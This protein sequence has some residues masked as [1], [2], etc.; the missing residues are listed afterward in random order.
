MPQSQAVL[1]AAARLVRKN[2]DMQTL[3]IQHF[4]TTEKFIIGKYDLEIL[5]L[6]RIKLDKVD[7]AQ[8]KTT[9][10]EIPQAGSVTI[11]K[12]GE[13]P[14]QLFLEENNKQVWVCNLNSSLTQETINLQPGKYRIEYRPKNAK[15]VIYSIERRFKIDSGISTQVK[16]Y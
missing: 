16:L 14:G 11:A 7:V 2:G 9:F 1:R 8:S 13:G 3:H 4:N 15:E 5:T 12:P 6:P 10:I